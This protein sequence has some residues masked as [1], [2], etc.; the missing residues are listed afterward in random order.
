MITWLASYPKSGNTWM[1]VFLTNYL[2]DRDA[3]ADIND[4]EGG[5]IASA[6]QWFD[7]WAGV[8]A[9]L[10]S[11]D[12]IERLRPGVY[13]CMVREHPAMLYM[14]AHDAW[15]L[16]DQGEAIFP[17]DVTAGVVYIVRNPLDVTASFANHYGLTLEDAVA[18]LADPGYT[19]GRSLGGLND[20]LRQRIGAWS[21]HAQSWVDAP[22]LRVLIVRYEDLLAAPLETF[23]AVVQFVGLPLDNY[24]L[25]RAVE[26]SRFEALQKQEQS[27]G[28]CERSIKA[29]HSFFRRGQAGGW[30]EELT[31]ELARRVLAE[32]GSMMRRFGYATEETP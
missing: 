2:Q 4:L 30:K 14:K 13:R 23:G 15:G 6:R 21:G 7:E 8:E 10:L 18:A 17:P 19:L 11:D 20:Q 16:T 9:S 24:R 27:R 1:R 31:P 28:F 26:F 25:R 32:H 5:P 3:P 29:P 22:A 12:V